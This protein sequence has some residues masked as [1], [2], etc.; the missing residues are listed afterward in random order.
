MRRI[1][2]FIDGFNLYHAIDDVQLD[3]YKW[4]DLSKLASAFTSSKDEITAVYYFTAYATWM[5]DKYARHRVYVR[6]L[7]SKNVKI[8][9]GE[10]KQRDKQCRQCNQSYKTFEEKKTDVNIA[11]KLFQGAVHDLY[12]TA[13]V[14][15][16]DSDLVPSVEAV[17]ETFPHKTVGVVIPIGR[18][19]ESLKQAANFHMKMKLKHLI[20][21]QLPYEI[22]LGGITIKC[23]EKWREIK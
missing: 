21:C 9:F 14:V 8:V 5:P 12:D 1:A 10:F 4:L 18:R 7:E 20:S 11:I 17:K 2:F 15:S 16:G 22:N 3:K 13:V 6:A 23:P 19:A